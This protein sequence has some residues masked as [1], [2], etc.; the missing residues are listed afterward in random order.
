L[1]PD[2]L[3]VRPGA[4]NL[5]PS[6]V[7]AT[8]VESDADALAAL[9]NVRSVLPEYSGQVTLRYADRD[10]R[11]IAN[12]TTQNFPAARNWPVER[13]SFFHADDR[14]SYAAVAVLGR[15]VVDALFAPGDNPLGRFVL[16]NNVPF[17]VIGVMARKGA[18]PFG[19]D[20]DDVVFTPIS[21]GGLRLFGQRYVQNI[22]VQV[23][24]VG[25]I[26]QTMEAIRTTLITRHRSEDFQTHSMAALLETANTASDTLTLFLGSLALISLLV[27]GIG[28]M[29]IMLVSVAERTRE[30]GIRM[31]TGA[32]RFDILM[33]FNSEALAVCGLGGI[34]G[35]GLGL[36]LAS[37]FALIGQPVLITLKPVL[38]AFACAVATGLVFGFLPARKAASL[39]P[40]LAL[41][42][43]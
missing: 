27:G 2:L 15:S 18:T 34:I 17:Q 10:Y 8:L 6:G 37:L 26:E 13:G 42:T 29:N 7:T 12:G 30:I 14:R 23:W 22:T 11:S 1:G 21:T 24:D 43:H 32:R 36:A 39:D 41:A 19:G 38:L 9:P 3:V 28:V 35:V 20:M 33:Q 31:A 16:I 25:Q 5:R 4:P 40:V